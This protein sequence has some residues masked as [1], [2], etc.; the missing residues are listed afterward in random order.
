MK[1]KRPNRSQVMTAMIITTTLAVPAIMN[2]CGQV[3]FDK[4]TAL[5]SLDCESGQ[6]CV[7]PNGGGSLYQMV[8]QDLAVSANR[9]V[10]VLFVVDNSG[11]MIEEQVGIGAK[12][13]G[14][15]DKIKDLN[16]QIALT[17]TDPRENSLSPEGVAVAWGDG[18]F[19][20]FGTSGSKFILNSQEFNAAAAQSAL[21]DAI[22]VGAQGNATERGIRAAY[23]SVER[24]AVDGPYKSFFR[25]NAR[26]AV[27]VIS[28]EDECSRGVSGCPAEDRDKSRPA[29]FVN[30]VKARFGE[31]K[32]FSF[33]SIIY[34]P[35]DN[36]C[37]T[38]LVQGN[39]YAELTLL[40]GGLMGSVCAQDYA[41]PLADLG[42]RVTELV[43]ATSLKCIPQDVDNDGALDL[44]VQV[45]SNGE[46]LKSGYEVNGLTVTFA[47]ALPEG[48]Y[49]FEYFC[50][51]P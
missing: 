35:G 6:D 38:G 27:V 46:I 49:H 34:K 14:F 17:T 8:S 31:A 32:V 45:G 41:A 29:E 30:L 19:R 18:Q 23:R 9:D 13:S 26:L 44:K 28:D 15:L 47:D 50:L 37:K 10:D 22:F 25:P 21:S 48:S 16:W 12:I 39:T 24:A 1:I 4:S 5:S 40:T 11:S 43:K 7:D 20:A 42:N 3:R 2:S 33:N 51:K 36:T